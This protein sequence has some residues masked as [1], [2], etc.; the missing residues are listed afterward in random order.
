M[1]P[2]RWKAKL[3]KPVG[4]SNITFK[5]VY[6]DAHYRLS[7]MNPAITSDRG[8]LEIFHVLSHDPVLPDFR[9]RWDQNQNTVDVEMADTNGKWRKDGFEEHH[10]QSF[11]DDPRILKVEIRLGKLRVLDGLLT[12]NLG[13]GVSVAASMQMFDASLQ[14]IKNFTEEAK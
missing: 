2:G 6:I 12:L 8:L 9:G 14:A 13:H 7:V 4:A 1:E 3:V 11:C 10:T 5:T